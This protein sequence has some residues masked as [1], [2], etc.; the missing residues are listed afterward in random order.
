[1]SVEKS[2]DDPRERKE[3]FK[4]LTTQELRERFL[5]QK[6]RNIF[7]LG[8]FGTANAVIVAFIIAYFN[9][10]YLQ[11]FLELSSELAETIFSYSIAAG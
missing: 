5:S 1:M 7:A 3:R 10:R 4:F 9:L 2:N 6:V 8:V 11:E